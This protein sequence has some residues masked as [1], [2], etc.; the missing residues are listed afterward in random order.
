M[1]DHTNK[2]NAGARTAR[3]A[4][5]M[6]GASI[7]VAMCVAPTASAGSTPRTSSVAIAFEAVQAVDAYSDWSRS[8]EASDYSRFERERD[9]VATLTADELGLDTAAVRE[10]LA[11]TTLFKQHLVL[12]AITQLGVPY[13]S[14]QSKEGEGFDCSGL[15]SWAFGDL[16]LTVPRNSGDQFDAAENRA[17]DEAVAGD[18]VYYPGHIGIY[19]GGEIYIHSPY[20]GKDVEIT[21][22][23][24]RSYDFA[25]IVPFQTIGATTPATDSEPSRERVITPVGAHGGSSAR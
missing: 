15:T 11:S 1:T 22:L 10:N 24:S 5:L 3:R 16:G 19:L 25:D 20:S 17:D 4:A 9:D 8:G 18:L 7:G 6:A 21:M 13:Q 2:L 14:M 12:T 23:P